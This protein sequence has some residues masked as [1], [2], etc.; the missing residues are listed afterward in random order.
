MHMRLVVERHWIDPVCLVIFD[1]EQPEQSPPVVAR[2]NLKSGE[3]WR[4]R[5]TNTNAP[6]PAIRE[7]LKA[8]GFPANLR[9]VR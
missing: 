1:A 3:L 7:A 8:K 2:A 9:L 4:T 6:M 5:G